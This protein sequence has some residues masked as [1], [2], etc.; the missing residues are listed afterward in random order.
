M[1]WLRPVV[2]IIAGLVVA[3]PLQL[4][5]Q[6]GSAGAMTVDEVVARALA[7]NPDLRAVRAEVDAAVGRMKQAGL[8]PN[9][10]L[11]LGGQKAISPDSNLSIGVTLPLDLN[12][13]VDGRVGVAQRELEM[14]RAQVAERERRLTADV[15]LKG[16]EL[17]A[18]RRNVEVTDE[19]LRINREAQRLV[20]DRVREGAAPALEENLLLVEVNRLDASRQML[21]SRVTVMSLQLKALAGMEPDAPLTLRGELAGASPAVS[22]AKGVAQALAGRPDLEVARADAAMARARIRKEE[23]EGRWDASV[24]VGYQR[25]DFGFSGLRGVTSNGSLQPIQDVFHYFGGGVSITLPMRNR[26]QGNVAAAVAETRAAERRQEFMV[27]V[28]RQEVDAAFTQLDAARRALALYERGVRDVA[29][30]NFEVVRRTWELGRGTLLN[31][32][33]EQRR[34]IEIENGYTD[35]LKQVFDA[36]VEIERA[37]G[38]ITTTPRG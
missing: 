27:L 15:R 14:R 24:S 35:A 7:D 30:R 8:R 33:T 2:G 11:E 21:E 16:G 3:A 26:N 34:L 32:I 29:R 17:L 36:T 18:A 10:M 9:P 31:V 12:G 13:R 5:A 4:F 37:V 38:P 19:L 1:C 22:R 28:I 6:G 25:Q 20:G 23:A